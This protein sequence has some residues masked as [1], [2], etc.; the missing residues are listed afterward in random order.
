MYLVTFKSLK[1]KFVTYALNLFYFFQPF[2]AGVL[3]D[4]ATPSVSSSS[5]LATSYGTMSGA[6]NVNQENDEIN[7]NGVHYVQ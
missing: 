5:R 7:T 2:V 4:S 6:T 1:I 3:L